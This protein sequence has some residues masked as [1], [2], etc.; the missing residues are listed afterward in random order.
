[1]RAHQYLRANGNRSY[2][3]IHDNQTISYGIVDIQNA[4]YPVVETIH[5][6]VSIDRDLAINTAKSI[7]DKLGYRRW[8]SFVG[9]QKKVARQLGHIITV[10][11]IAK[12]HIQDV[13]EVSPEKIRVIYNG[14]D[15]DIF[16]PSEQVR[17][18][19]DTI[20][21]IMSRDTAVKGLRFLLEAFAI[22]RRTYNLKLVVVGKTLGDGETEKYINR[23]GITTDVSFKD[24]IDTGELI[25]LYRSATLV[26]V[27]ST[28]EGFGLPAA[29][30]MSCGAPVVSTTAGALPEVVGDAGI[31]VQP[32]DSPALAE[33][34]KYLI[35][36]PYKRLEYSEKGRNRI[37]EKFNWANAAKNTV[38]VY[39]QAIENR[40]IKE[41]RTF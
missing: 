9:M 38:D 3:V 12:K 6:P 34:I 31:L 5:H 21:M 18:Q 7:K 26:A 16:S 29:E 10:S 22:L 41:K 11:E 14:I 17:R 37:L 23:L 33:A 1:M 13:F 19:E 27:P 36:N 24:Q 15:T 2:D 25:G 28:Y 40:L 32:A 30:A 4:G 8:F 39:S 35:D 20:L